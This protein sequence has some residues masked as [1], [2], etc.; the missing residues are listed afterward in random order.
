MESDVLSRPRNS[1]AVADR[2]QF[3]RN[4][5]GFSPWI[6]TCVP[7]PPPAPIEMPDVPVAS[8]AG[9][10][11]PDEGKPARHAPMPGGLEHAARQEQE[12]R[13]IDRWGRLTC[14]CPLNLLRPPQTDNCRGIALSGFNTAPPSIIRLGGAVCISGL[15][16][17]APVAGYCPR[18][19]RSP[20]LRAV[21]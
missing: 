2:R 7:L 16:R 4:F 6:V 3:K 15:F 5:G 11:S 8:F 19:T 9:R 17:L 13:E 18:L 14:L 10:P 21:S 12:L 20:K 1:Q